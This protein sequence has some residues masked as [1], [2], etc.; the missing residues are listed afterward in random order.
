VSQIGGRLHNF[1]GL[2]RILPL[3]VCL[4]PGEPLL[5]NPLLGPI[6]QPTVDPAQGA[7]S[8]G[9]IESLLLAA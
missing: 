4:T 7:T 8:A 2:V 9:S 6:L 5:D 1:E 3:S